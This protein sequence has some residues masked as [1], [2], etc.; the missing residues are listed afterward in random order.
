MNEPVIPGI[1]AGIDFDAQNERLVARI[2]ECLA[3]PLATSFRENLERLARFAR[4][5]GEVRIGMDF[6]DLSFGFAVFRPDGSC[7]IVGGL[8]YGDGGEP[9]YSVCIRPVEGWM[10]HT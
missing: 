7:R 8:I 10:I 4:S 1:P 6:A 2:Q 3:H 5:G 9:T